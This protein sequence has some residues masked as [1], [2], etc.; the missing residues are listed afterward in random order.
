MFL[1]LA[2]LLRVDLLLVLTMTV[3]VWL[4]VIVSLSELGS[5]CKGPQSYQNTLIGAPVLIIIQ[6]SAVHSRYTFYSS[7]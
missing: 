6:P 3:L 2:V 1:Q 5:S 4:F 7:P